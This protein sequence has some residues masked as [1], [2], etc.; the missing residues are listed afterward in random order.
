MALYILGHGYLT[1]RL[2]PGAPIAE[3]TSWGRIG[4]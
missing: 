1:G 2:E 3:A 4:A